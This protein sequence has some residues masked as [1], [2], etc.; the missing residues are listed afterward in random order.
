[1]LCAHLIN[2]IFP[3][4]SNAVVIFGGDFNKL[5][6]SRLAIDHGLTQVVDQ[7]THCKSLLDKCFTNRPD[8]LNSVTIMSSLINTKHKAVL[9][10]RKT[11]D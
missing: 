6:C 8:L 3:S 1:M 9:L 5:D 4:D 7:V 11:D 10:R 2:D